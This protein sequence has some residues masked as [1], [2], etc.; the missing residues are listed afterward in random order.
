MLLALFVRFVDPEKARTPRRLVGSASD[1]ALVRRQHRVFYAIV[2]MA[3][4]EWWWCGRPASILQ[5]LGLALA[6]AGVV[7]YRRAGRSLG[8]QL[9]PLVA[10]SEPAVLVE[11]GPYRSIRH[12]MYLAELAMAFGLPLLLGAYWSLGLSLVFTAVVL[13]RIGV[14]ED[15]LAARLPD[16]P[17]YAART[18]RLVPHV[19]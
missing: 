19:Y 12:P 3:P 15:A 16:Y 11:H 2:S 10:P 7:G 6:V 5:V 18:A 8:D 1:L 14:E 13:H 4:V 9:G 17:S